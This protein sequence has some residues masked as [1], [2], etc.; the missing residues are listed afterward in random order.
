MFIL[1]SGRLAG[2]KTISKLFEERREAGGGGGERLIPSVV[3]IL[4]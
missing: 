3:L 1:Q 4:C 2:M